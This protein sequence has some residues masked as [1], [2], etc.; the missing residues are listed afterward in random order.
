MKK[1]FLL[2]LVT[3]ISFSAFGMRN[4]N[5]RRRL[6]FD[7][8]DNAE[9]AVLSPKKERTQEESNRHNFDNAIHEFNNA[10][11]LSL[12]D[13][14][15]LYWALSV[16]VAPTPRE[17]EI[18]S[19][20]AKIAYNSIM[21]TLNTLESNSQN[22]ELLSHAMHVGLNELATT[23]QKKENKEK[24]Q[25]AIQSLQGS[26]VVKLVCYLLYF[27]KKNDPLSTPKEFIHNPGLLQNVIEGYKK[28][29][30][31]QVNASD[32]VKNALK[33][34]LS[35]RTSIDQLR[36][37]NEK[38]IAITNKWIKAVNNRIAFL[39]SYNEFDTPRIEVVPMDNDPDKNKENVASALDALADTAAGL[40]INDTRGIIANM[41]AVTA[42]ISP[43]PVP[44]KQ[45]LSQLSEKKLRTLRSLR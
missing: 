21:G 23:I 45:P 13:L 27:N 33:V 12:F 11:S 16:S 40:Q 2:T 20:N 28:I 5:S 29:G 18:I 31:L 14:K 43:L 26:S 30:V 19:D 42:P 22:M 15:S 38:D 8:A 37:S 4:P 1:I 44:V 25:L 3:G 7:N 35:Q 41:T 24:M 17:K 9:S 10:K 32:N 39:N 36:K 6:T 34:Y